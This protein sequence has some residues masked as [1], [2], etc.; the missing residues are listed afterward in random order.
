MRPP[1]PPDDAITHVLLSDP[2]VQDAWVTWD[3]N[4]TVAWAVPKRAVTGE[5]LGLLLRERLGEGAPPVVLAP[6]MPLVDGVEHESLPTLARRAEV[7]ERLRREGIEAVVLVGPRRM[8]EVFEPL[9]TLL[10]EPLRPGEGGAVAASAAPVGITA[11]AAGNGRPS[12]LDGG[13]RPAV[14]GLPMTLPGLLR[15]AAE[16]HGAKT[17]TFLDVEGRREVLTF[18]DLWTQALELLG[19]LRAQGVREGERVVLLL[20]RPGDFVRCFWACTLGGVVPVPL[21]FPPSFERSHPGVARLLSVAERLGGPLVLT[22]E[23]ALAPLEALGLRV[24]APSRLGGA[25]PGTVVEVGPEAPAVVSFTSGS[26]GRPKGV[27][28]SQSRLVAMPDAMLAGGWYSAED[29]G[30]SWMPLDHVAGTAYPHLVSLRAGTSHV[31]VARDYVLAD[32][33]R[34]LDLLTEF[35]ATMSWAPNFAYGLVADRL[36]RGERRAWELSRVRV[37]SCAG[38]PVLSETMRRFVAPLVRHGLREDAICPMWGMAET[39]SFFTATRG[40]RTHPGESAVELGPPPAGSALRVVDDQDT[41]VGEGTVGHLQVRGAQVLA[42]YLEDGDLNARS[43]TADG[44]FRTGDLA[45]VRDGQMAISGRQKEVLILNGNNVY[46]QEIEE[47]VERVEGVL[48]SYTVAC[49]TRAPGSQTDEVVVFF[50]PT[51][52]APP[53]AGLLRD[54]REYVG[55]TLGFAVAHLVPLEKHQV[56]RTELG[57]RGRTELRRRFE[58]GELA[59]ERRKALRVLG[60]PSTMPACLAVPTWSIHVPGPVN[61]GVPPSVA[62][63]VRGSG[64]PNMATG[65]DVATQM[66]DAPLDMAVAGSIPAAPAPRVPLVVVAGASFL[67]ALRARISGREVVAVRLDDPE[68]LVHALTATAVEGAATDVVFAASVPDGASREA[69]ATGIAPLLRLLQSLAS[70]EHATPVRLWAVALGTTS[71][72]EPSGSGAGLAALLWPGLLASAAAEVAGLE[73]RILWVPAGDAEATRFV[74]GQ[75]GSLRFPREVTWGGGGTYLE[76]RYLTWGPRPVKALRRL[77]PGGLYLITGALGGL[78]QAWA[79]HLRRG[80]GARLLLVGRRQKDAAAESLERELGEALY[81]CA[82]V[83]DA[84]ALTRAVQHAEAHFGRPCDGAF[85]FAGTREQGPLTEQTPDSLVRGA[86]AHA[87]GAVAVAEALRERPQAPLVF[88][89]SLMGTL[90]AGLNASYCAASGFVERFAH[91]LVVEGRPAV[92]VSFSAVR[93]TGMAVGMTASPPGYRMLE[94]TQALA[95]LALAV[96]SPD[97]PHVLAGVDGEAL[98]WRTPGLRTEQSL[99]ALHVFYA[100]HQG[101]LPDWCAHAGQLHPLPA[102][103]RT[104]DGAVDR[105]ALAAQAFG[106]S[107]DDAPEPFEDV[108]VEAFREVLGG[109]QVG[110]GSDFFSLGGSSLQAFRVVARL[111]ARTGLH[112]REVALFE[113]PS[114]RELAAHL[115]QSVD[116][117]RLDVSSLTDEQVGLLLRVLHPSGG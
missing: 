66:H 33:P 116:P 111:N 18:A 1:P 65:G 96:E 109:G 108:V 58:A 60:G 40:V 47:A 113:H 11:P 43:F 73:V 52:D 48:P 29:V 25:G 12:V 7:E 93:D 54:I 23:R 22:G 110:A 81:V 78:G 16:R 27:V 34:W 112:L 30:L 106:A 49:P 89:A 103:P 55:R 37:L 69:L 79:R 107:A 8:E 72:S 38:E 76:R 51:P 67:E 4:V 77:V 74:A 35:G 75:L 84:A 14:P 100:R 80:L 57:K 3:N 83:T 87:L 5:A 68:A 98:P 19:G 32:V 36:E 41:V 99:E 15:H 95:A 44:W 117:S 13:P 28:L 42:G 114:V 104:P 86:E 61:G 20:E 26:T 70:R 62:A 115:R 92:V 105:E 102:L 71:F 64:A 24:L 82:D 91:R 9:D 17:V 59:A 39:S 45:V 50:V 21:A 31:L 53:L 97:T 85:H 88:A 46:P 56:P 101:P 10:P 90:G 94:P 6:A 63:Q 2:R